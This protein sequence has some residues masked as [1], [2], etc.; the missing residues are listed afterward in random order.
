MLGLLIG[1]AW[2]VPYEFDA[3]H[4]LLPESMPRL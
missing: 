1:D 3:P 2:G 4:E